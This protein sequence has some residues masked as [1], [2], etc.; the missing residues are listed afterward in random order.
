MVSA[1][2]AV[3]RTRASPRPVI[4]SEVVVCKLQLLGSM[5]ISTVMP[6]IRRALSIRSWRGSKAKWVMILRLGTDESRPGLT[7][8]M[9]VFGKPG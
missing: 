6:E 1:S 5:S 2:G 3:R 9:V 8:V 7:W 4:G